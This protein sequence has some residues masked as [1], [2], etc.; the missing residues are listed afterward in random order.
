MMVEISEKI[1]QAVGI[2]DVPEGDALAPT[3]ADADD[4][5][6]EPLEVEG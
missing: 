6:A 2:E 3:D 1:R 5:D 4:V